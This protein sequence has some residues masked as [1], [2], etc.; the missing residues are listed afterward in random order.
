MSAPRSINPIWIS[1]TVDTSLSPMAYSSA[2][3]GSVVVDM[4]ANSTTPRGLGSGVSSAISPW[5]ELRRSLPS[6]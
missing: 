2:T 5:E 3:V 4:N 1:S 6:R